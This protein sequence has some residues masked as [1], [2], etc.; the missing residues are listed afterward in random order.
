MKPY[1]LAETNWKTV[2]DLKI[3]LAVLPWGATEAHNY[4]LPYSTDNIMAESVAKD[5]AR[6]AW[7]KGAKVIILPAIPFG[8]NTGQ[9]DIKLNIN[10]NPGTQMAIL[11][12]IADVLNRHG[13]LKFLILNGHGG[14]DFRQQI[15]EL[16]F[17]FPKLFI[18]S[19]NWYQ[20][21]D[22]SS[23]F[24]N[25]GDHANEM[26]TSMMQFIAPEL[27]LPLSE[28]GKGESKK[29]RIKAFGEKW[30]WAERKWT[31]ISKDT[32]IGDP[33]R[34]TPEKGEKCYQEVIGKISS[35]MLDLSNA[36]INDMYE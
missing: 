23:Y 32:G 20:T 9:L 2:K 21:F 33:S 27:V 1:I 34:A 6:I 5:S 18:C 22:N 19:C 28:A 24:E 13:I 26:E 25:G 30:A 35:F 31:K 8:V 3:E 10:M 15:R 17:R 36:D 4:H 11:N 7:E 12:D 14:N 29:F 16:G